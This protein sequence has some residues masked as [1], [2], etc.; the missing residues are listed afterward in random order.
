MT[1]YQHT[2]QLSEQAEGCINFATPMENNIADIFNTNVFTIITTFIS[3]QISEQ[4]NLVLDLTYL[5]TINLVLG[6]VTFLLD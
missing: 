2:L 1:I 3:E 5:D 4:V 6:Y